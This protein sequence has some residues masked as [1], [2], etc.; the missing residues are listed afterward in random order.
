MPAWRAQV[1]SPLLPNAGSRGE[2]LPSAMSQENVEIVRR[3]LESFHAGDAD[4]ALECFSPDVVLDASRRFDGRI[5]RGRDELS[6]IIGEWLGAW[7]DWRE[8]INAIR[9]L[10]DRVIVDSTQRGR[11]KGSG[12]EIETRYA[13]L[14]ELRD[15]EITRMTLYFDVDEALEAAGP[16]D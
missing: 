11:G 9:D 16:T 12:I 15:G 4:G 5:G 8:E 14:Y 13:T 6:T 1:H 7:D 3:M 10:G 2:I